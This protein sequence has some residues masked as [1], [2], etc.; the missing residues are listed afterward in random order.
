[1]TKLLLQVLYETFGKRSITLSNHGCTQKIQFKIEIR[2]WQSQVE[3]AR[4]IWALIRPS[5]S[6]HMFLV[7]SN[8]IV[9][10][11]LR[12]HFCLYNGLELVWSELTSVW[13]RSDQ[14]PSWAILSIFVVF[15][16]QMLSLLRINNTAFWSEPRWVSDAWGWPKPRA[17]SDSS[18]RSPHEKNWN[19]CRSRRFY[20][21]LSKFILSVKNRN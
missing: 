13:G 9:W 12:A 17:P 10:N 14:R 19:H 5:S 11:R 15:Y 3:V 16:W 4:P 6:A 2:L 20:A 7:R 8:Y 1:M 21:K 18:C